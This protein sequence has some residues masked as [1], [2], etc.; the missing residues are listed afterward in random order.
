MGRLPVWT[1]SQGC[2]QTPKRQTGSSYKDSML[3]RA[4]CLLYTI[5]ATE[6]FVVMSKILHMFYIKSWKSFHLFQM[7]GNEHGK[8]VRLSVSL[9]P[10]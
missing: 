6:S 2:H 5:T 3:V 4:L 7:E 8:C 1:F 9:T 10:T